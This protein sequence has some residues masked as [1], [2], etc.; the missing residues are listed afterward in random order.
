MPGVSLMSTVSMMNRMSPF[1]EVFGAKVYHFWNA[2]MTDATTGQV[3][4][5][6]IVNSADGTCSRSS[7]T[8]SFTYNEG[9]MVRRLL[10]FISEVSDAPKMLMFPTQIAYRYVSSMWPLN[11]ISI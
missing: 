6:Y 7:P 1:Y 3:I 9:L 11:A 5:H 8:E 10:P 2:T 4:D